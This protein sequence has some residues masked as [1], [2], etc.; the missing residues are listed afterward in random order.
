MSIDCNNNFAGRPFRDAHHDKLLRTDNDGAVDV[1]KM[2]LR[3]AQL[4]WTKATAD[5]ADFA[6][7]Q[8]ADRIDC[9]DMRTTVYVVR[10]RLALH[11]LQL[12][13]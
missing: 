1:A 2:N 9:V 5:Y 12:S 13:H 8:R 4:A 11:A 6:T 7:R 3:A 10:T